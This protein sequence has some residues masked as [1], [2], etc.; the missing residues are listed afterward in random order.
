MLKITIKPFQ[1][2]S[3]TELYKILQ[4]RNEV[5]I[6]EQNCPYQDLDD[7]DLKALHVIGKDKE[8]M[9]AYTRIFKSGDSMERASIG[10][11]V[12]R[13]SARKYGFGQDIIQVSIEAI[14]KYFKETYIQL[15]AQVYLKKFYNSFGFV[16]KGAE[17]LEDDIPHI[18]MEKK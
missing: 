5:F 13:Q 10:R 9:V 6:V 7:K 14:E 18:L 3:A 8:E 2:L 12:V 17:Y 15:S 16:E 1:E 4:L 11:V